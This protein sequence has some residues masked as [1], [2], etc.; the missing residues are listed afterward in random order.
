MTIIPKSIL[1]LTMLIEEVL[2]IS[3][4]KFVDSAIVLSDFLKKTFYK[5]FR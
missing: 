1:G 4:I 2:P 5:A 3:K